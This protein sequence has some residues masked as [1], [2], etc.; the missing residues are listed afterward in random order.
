M[1]HS[2]PAIRDRINAVNSA[3]KSASGEHKLYFHPKCK[4]IIK[5]LE[6]QVYKPGTSVPDNSGLEHM[7][8][9]LGY[10]VEFLYPV[11]RKYINTNIPQTWGVK[12]N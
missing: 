6:R 11:T 10:M 2:H 9:A 8:D 12:V 3:L 1:R 7:G 4:S 5:T